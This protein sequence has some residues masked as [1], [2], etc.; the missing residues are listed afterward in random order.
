L[1]GSNKS[2]SSNPSPISAAIRFPSTP[3]IV[4]AVFRSVR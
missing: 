3:C 2:A 4:G 1:R